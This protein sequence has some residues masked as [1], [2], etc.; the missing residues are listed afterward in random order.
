MPS[1]SPTR[2]QITPLVLAKGLSMLLVLAIF[3]QAGTF[4]LSVLHGLRAEGFTPI[5]A[6]SQDATESRVLLCTAEG[7][8]WVSVSA[9]SQENTKHQPLQTTLKPF[10][11]FCILG[12]SALI[13]A[14]NGL[15]IPL[16]SFLGFND[17]KPQD[18][19]IL[20]AAYDM[21]WPFSQGPPA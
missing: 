6:Q 15:A 14:A 2:R 7:L 1:A 12:A 10:C 16:P 19:A 11:P 5:L 9:L 21:A 20:A 13:A 3:L 17:K 18:R 8:K 4:A